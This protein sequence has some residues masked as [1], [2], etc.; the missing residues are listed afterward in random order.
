MTEQYPPYN[1]QESGRLQG[2]SVDL[3][4]K[5]WER[6]GVNLN[7]SVILL[8]P[9]TEG[10]NR[11][12]KENNTV[13]FTTFRIPERE[14]LFKWVGP[15]ASGRD[16]LLVKN[17][18]ISINAEQDLKKYKI[19]AIE[20]DC[21]V[22]RLLDKG[23]NK[24]ELILEKSS[25]PVIDMLENGTVD[26]W[27]YNDMAGIWLIQDSGKNASDYRVAYVLGRDEGYYAFNKGTS[28]SLVQSFQQALDYIKGNKDSSGSSDYEKILRKNTPA[29]T[30]NSRL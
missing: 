1:Y 12:L 5:I 14:L 20:N 18:N 7:R 26:A 10:Y 23:V 15:V 22:Q 16:V 2:I 6:M 30:G 25:K 17:K 24:E 11:T 9:W 8:L 3:L 29:Y 19:A 27:A 4:E 13:L 28:D 21:A